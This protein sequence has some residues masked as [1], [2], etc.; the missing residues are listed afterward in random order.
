MTRLASR[1]AAKKQPEVSQHRQSLT[2]VSRSPFEVTKLWGALQQG[3]FWRTIDLGAR[4]G[5]AGERSAPNGAAGQPNLN[6]GS[7]ARALLFGC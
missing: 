4:G 6:L 1:S 2:W 5:M 7:L 3:W